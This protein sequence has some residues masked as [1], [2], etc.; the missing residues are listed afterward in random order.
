[1]GI[2]DSPKNAQSLQDSA[3]SWGIVIDD[4]ALLIEDDENT[5]YTV[6]HDGQL[7]LEIFMSCQTQWL[8]SMDGITG[9]NYSGVISVIELYAKKKAHLN[10]LHEVSAIERGFL[11]A[12]NEKRKKD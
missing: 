8:Y 7:A 5:D 9:L 6:F 1:M 4:D 10:L 2:S 3:D 12:I 11:N